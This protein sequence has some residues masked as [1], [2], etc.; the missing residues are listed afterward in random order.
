MLVRSPVL[1]LA[2]PVPADAVR[3]YTNISLDP[4][5]AASAPPADREGA[6]DVASNATALVRESLRQLPNMLAAL[7]SPGSRDRAGH[8]DR[9]HTSSGGHARE[10]ELG[11]G[12]RA[13]ATARAGLRATSW[14]P[15]ATAPLNASA[16]VLDA[17]S[18]AVLSAAVTLYRRKLVTALQRHANA[19]VRT[20]RAA[21]APS[22]AD[23]HETRSSAR[24]GGAPSVILCPTAIGAVHTASTPPPFPHAPPPAQLLP[25]PASTAQPSSSS[26]SSSSAPR[27]PPQAVGEE[28]LV[29]VPAAAVAPEGPRPGPGYGWLELRCRVMGVRQ[30]HAL[31]EVAA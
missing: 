18:N 28:L 1:P 25:A 29:T 27:Q 30:V 21:R 15:R 26:P 19:T 2:L 20:D 22:L 7:P 8:S 13:Q 5:G 9:S 17:S 31:G 12:A 24:A 16:P 14:A 23:G 10:K 3:R 11:G 4:G 6:G